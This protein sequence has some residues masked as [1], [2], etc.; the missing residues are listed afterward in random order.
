MA[1]SL[2]RVGLEVAGQNEI[3]NIDCKSQP[4]EV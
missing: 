4:V 1:V 3:G 2:T